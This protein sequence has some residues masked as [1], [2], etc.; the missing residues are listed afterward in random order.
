MNVSPIF[1]AYG[2]QPSGATNNKGKADKADWKP[3]NS[4]SAEVLISGASS[5]A[6]VVRD[7]IAKLPDVRIPMV[8]EIQK[9]I[10]N[11][12]YPLPNNLVHAFDRMFD[13]GILA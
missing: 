9:K 4:P 13:A 2:S 8:E 11:N 1:A 12:D 7:Q 3:A 5:D 6:Q 10:Q